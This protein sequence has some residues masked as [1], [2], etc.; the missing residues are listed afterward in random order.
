MTDLATMAR[1]ALPEELAPALRERALALLS[2]VKVVGTHLHDERPRQDRSE[3]GA[4][5]VC[6][7]TGGHMGGHHVRPGDN[8]SV[9]P[10]HP[11]C[12]RKLHRRGKP[13]R[14]AVAGAT[15]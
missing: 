8:T 13:R 10:V 14:G 15:G 1:E 11:A 7:K 12:H 5:V 2:E 9:V 3:R 4:C 6:H